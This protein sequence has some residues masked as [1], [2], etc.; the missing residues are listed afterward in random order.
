MDGKL[1]VIFLY[2]ILVFFLE[3]FIFCFCPLSSFQF[4]SLFF[5]NWLQCLS[6][7]NMLVMHLISEN[8]QIS[9]SSRFRNTSGYGV[10]FEAG[11]ET[12]EKVRSDLVAEKKWRAERKESGFCSYSCFSESEK[13]MCEK[14]LWASEIYFVHV[15]H[16][17]AVFM[18]FFLFMRFD[19]DIV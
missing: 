8:S 19:Y 11:N 16:L 6:I 10:N 1:H 18:Q 4:S 14:I 7:G 9:T 2:R 12:R 3:N 13:L 5:V 15:R 17:K